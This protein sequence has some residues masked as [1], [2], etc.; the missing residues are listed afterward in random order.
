MHWFIVTIITIRAIIIVFFVIVA[1]D[2][3]IVLDCGEGNG[4]IVPLN[5]FVKFGMTRDMCII[6]QQ[7]GRRRRGRQ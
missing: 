6:L 7:I 2:M 1:T 5:V 4:I 3:T